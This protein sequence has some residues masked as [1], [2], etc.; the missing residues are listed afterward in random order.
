MKLLEAN[1]RF[2]HKMSGK[3]SFVFILFI[4]CFVLVI[5][6][7]SRFRGQFRRKTKKLYRMINIPY[8]LSAMTSYDI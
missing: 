2:T 5:E 3:S 8:V 4:F 6:T 7:E 1:E